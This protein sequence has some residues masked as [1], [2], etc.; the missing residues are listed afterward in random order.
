MVENPTTKLTNGSR[1]TR[2]PGLVLIAPKM[3]LDAMNAM[4][5]NFS[6]LHRTVAKIVNKRP[7]IAF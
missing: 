2:S 4:Q 5:K 6:L 3:R 7:K 1:T